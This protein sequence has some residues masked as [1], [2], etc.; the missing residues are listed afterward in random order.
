M[1]GRGARLAGQLAL[2][3][4]FL[5][6]LAA[7]SFR[8]LRPRAASRRA[9]LRQNLALGATASLVHRGAVLP[10]MLLVARRC[11]GAGLA[12]LV[13]GPRWL[14][15]AAAFALLDYTTYLWHR[16]N[17]EARFLWRFH[18]VHHT[19]VD[20]DVTTAARFHPGEIALSVI[21]AAIQV[22][23]AGPRPA[24]AAAYA[25]AMQIAA[26]FH[27]ANLRLPPGLDRALAAIVVTPRM[28][29]VHH[30]VRRDEAGANWSVI[31]SVWDRIHRTLRLDVPAGRLTIGLPAYRDPRELGVARL[32]GM[33]FGRQRAWWQPHA[34]A[35]SGG[36][37][38]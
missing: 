9:R 13:P 37:R 16:S 11:Q 6:L 10:V 15:D 38:G 20:L 32:L 22:R 34:P 23:I 12:R 29:G 19:D 25:V 36:G 18:A 28:H 33:P 24:V 5:A 31:F 4:A 14:R 21:A 30:S 26:A 8:P 7:E 35:T 27:H 17:H 2:A 1:S 3:G